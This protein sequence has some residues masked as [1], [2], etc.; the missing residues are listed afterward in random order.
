LQTG[1]ELREEALADFRHYL[2]L[3]PD[4]EHAEQAR[5]YAAKIEAELATLNE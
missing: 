1:Q 2:E 4:G 3:A 5:E